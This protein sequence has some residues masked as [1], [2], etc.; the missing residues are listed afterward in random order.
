MATQAMCI[1]EISAINTWQ[2]HAQELNNRAKQLV[3]EALNALREFSERAKG[4]IFDEM[5]NLSNQVINGMTKVLE[6]MQMLFDAITEI[7]NKV[8]AM[9]DNILQGIIQVA[10]KAIGA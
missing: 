1:A 5:K 10:A 3:D 2:Q 4:N 8:Q 6:G 9:L 7:K